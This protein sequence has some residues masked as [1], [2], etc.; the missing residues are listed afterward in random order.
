MQ[1]TSSFS[2]EIWT[3]WNLT[4]LDFAYNQGLW[5]RR[6]GLSRDFLQNGAW[7]ELLRIRAFTPTHRHFA[8]FLKCAKK[9]AP[10][11][12]WKPRWH[13]WC[14][15]IQHDC[16][17]IFNAAKSQNKTEQSKAKQSKR[18]QKQKKKKTEIFVDKTKQQQQQK[19]QH[20]Q[21]KSFA[22]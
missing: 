17:W 13:G 2:K 12:Q 5:K 14:G 20:K 21:S 15:W 3:K 7:Y 4:N 16:F 18:K 22:F 6:A 19:K 10:C 8:P 9:I 11:S 1:Y